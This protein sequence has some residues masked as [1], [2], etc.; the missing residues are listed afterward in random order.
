MGDF[1]ERDLYTHG[2]R[3]GLNLIETARAYDFGNSEA[4]IGKVIKKIGRENIVLL[5]KFTPTPDCSY[6]RIMESVNKSLQTLGVSSIDILLGHGVDDL[7]VL[8]HANMIRAFSELR[9]SG[10]ARFSG[11]STHSARPVLDWILKNGGYDVVLLPFHFGM[12][13]EITDLITK[14]HKSGIGILGM[15]SA[16]LNFRKGADIRRCSL[17]ALRYAMGQSF[18]DSVLVRIG[19]YE[20]LDEVIEALRKPLDDTELQSLK[21]AVIGPKLKEYR[22]F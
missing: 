2:R 11:V 8:S 10:K 21:E 19:S 4:N 7:A 14:A 16:F 15:K 17:D 13:G 6:D 1:A 3:L 9:K 18:I 20:E 5:T 12:A 22:P